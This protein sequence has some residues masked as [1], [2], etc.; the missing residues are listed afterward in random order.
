[1]FVLLSERGMEWVCGVWG[2]YATRRRE[3]GKRRRQEKGKKK[4]KGEEDEDG[5]EVKAKIDSVREMK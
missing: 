3:G 5:K 2:I 4:G 1:M